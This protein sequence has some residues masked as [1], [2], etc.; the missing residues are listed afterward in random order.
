MPVADGR[1]NPALRRT[2]LCRHA[3]H[4]NMRRMM[5]TDIRV[6]HAQSRPKTFGTFVDERWWPT[7]PHAAGSRASTIMEKEGHLRL[8]LKPTL[9]HVSADRVSR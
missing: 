9:G 8:Y 6:V 7:Y 5:V 4:S 1:R 3:A 2:T